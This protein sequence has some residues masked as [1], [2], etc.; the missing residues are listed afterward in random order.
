M[1]ENS[2][3]AGSSS[4]GNPDEKS[5]AQSNPYPSPFHERAVLTDPWIE[6][7]V[8]PETKY[9]PPPRLFN[10]RPGGMTFL[11]GDLKCPP[12]SPEN[13]CSPTPLS[14]YFEAEDKWSATRSDKNDSWNE[15]DARKTLFLREYE[16]QRLTAKLIGPTTEITCGCFSKTGDLFVAGDLEGSVHVWDLSKLVRTPR[17]VE[18]DSL[19]VCRSRFAVERDFQARM[20]RLASGVS[21]FERDLDPMLPHFEFFSTAEGAPFVKLAS[22]ASFVKLHASHVID[23]CFDQNKITRFVSCG[24][25]GMAVVFHNFKPFVNIR[26]QSQS[27][28]TCFAFH[29]SNAK[30]GITG[31][32]DGTILVWSLQT[33]DASK[34]VPYF[35]FPSPTPSPVSSLEIHP[36]GTYL[37]ASHWTK[38]TCSI[39]RLDDQSNYEASPPYNVLNLQGP[40]V[41]EVL[42]ATWGAPSLILTVSSDVQCVWKLLQASEEKLLQGLLVTQMVSPYQLEYGYQCRTAK[43]IKGCSI[44]CIF[45]PF[46]FPDPK[47]LYL[48][49]IEAYKKERYEN[50]VTIWKMLVASNSIVEANNTKDTFFLSKTLQ[51]VEYAPFFNMETSTVVE[52][53]DRNVWLSGTAAAASTSAPAASSTGKASQAASNKKGDAKAPKQPAT[54]SKKVDPPT[55]NQLTRVIRPIDVDILNKTV[56]CVVLERRDILS[57]WKVRSVV[58]HVI[59]AFMRERTANRDTDV[60]LT[61][62]TA[63]IRLESTKTVVEL[64]L[65]FGYGPTY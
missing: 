65:D 16:S 52:E 50:A 4:N 23:V 60:F 15:D 59:H 51:P 18:A 27:P 37:L 45:D 62:R 56:G 26:P 14:L 8:T 41:N 35:V 47:A 46:R 28:I 58:K 1:S 30:I 34:T 42:K 33:S 39:W 31:S 22:S 24:H 10:G 13:F 5:S 61:T 11:R 43:F 63:D 12:G 55:F 40:H 44:R 53:G 3:P 6:Q 25:D 64:I 2:P 48:P 17:A 49:E 19:G 21:L 7:P 20:T 36:T 32:M 29:P 57:L 38:I 9:S 54:A